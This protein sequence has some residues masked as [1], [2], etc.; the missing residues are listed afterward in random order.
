M[1]SLIILPL[2]IMLVVRMIDP[3]IMAEHRSAAERAIEQPAS[4]AGVVIV[5]ATWLVLA[6]LAAWMIYRIAI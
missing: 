1:L 5:I 4:K 2:A 3:Q 6:T